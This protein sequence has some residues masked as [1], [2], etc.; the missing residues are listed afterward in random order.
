MN[1]KHVIEFDYWLRHRSKN[2]S[3]VVVAQYDVTKVGGCE[4]DLFMTSVLATPKSRT[5]LLTNSQWVTRN[6]FGK[7]EV[8]EDDGQVRI[9]EQVETCVG[10]SKDTRIEPFTFL[11]RWNDPW[12]HKFELIQNF[13][14]FYNLYFDAKDD[15]YVA[16]DG[17]GKTTV[18][19]K[20]RN[21][22]PHQK[23][24]IRTRFLRNYLAC[25]GRVLVRQHDNR[26]HG[27]KTLA[28]LGIEP[29]RGRRLDGSDYVFDL[30]MVDVGQ[31]GEGPV[32]SQLIGKDL[33]LPFGKRHDILGWPKGN[34]EF[35]IGVDDNGD[36]IMAS[37]NEGDGT[38]VFLTTV[39]FQREVLKKY[40]DARNYKVKRDA[41]SSSAWYIKKYT[42]KA[43]LVHVLL[44]DLAYLPLNEQRH[45]RN[46]NVPPE[47]GDPDEQFIDSD[48]LTYQFKESLRI[49]QERFE[50]RFGFR[51]FRL[52]GDDD[53]RKEDSIRV[54]LNDDPEE[55]EGQI[56]SLA[57]LLPD[58]INKKQLEQRLVSLL[59][60]DSTHLPDSIDMKQF[61]HLNDKYGGKNKPNSISMLEDFLKWK[62]LPTTI[63]SHLQK[64]QNL[65]SSGVA[66]RKGSKH[67]RNTDKYGLNKACGK[68]FIREL[69]VDMTRTFDNLS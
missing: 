69:F 1:V 21:D 19:I 58:S 18:V 9:E 54:P 52:L 55:F 63:I 43:D 4:V 48:T 49:F 25:R 41:V 37:Y 5:V 33:I 44:G 66:H 10:K 32:I 17:T 64:I 61:E 20:I 56:L 13:I 28:E 8:W 57:I 29:F 45:W 7:I 2:E 67:E 36:N 60:L 42:S 30:T 39:C 46:Y 62:S 31:F 68:E 59:S 34:S 22:T 65:R 47:V 16:V 3:W 11:R 14:L 27:D 23:I 26:V 53:A 12:P 15:K 35:I 24:E 6:D 50:N 51:L 40:Y 38:T